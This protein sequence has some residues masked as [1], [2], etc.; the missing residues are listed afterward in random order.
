MT[1]K[2]PGIQAS[3]NLAD[4]DPRGVGIALNGLSGLPAIDVPVGLEVARAQSSLLIT[5]R[6]RY[7]GWEIDAV[8]QYQFLND[9]D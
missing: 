5:I 6:T 3:L 2:A 9:K 8:K 7:S 4:M 1:I